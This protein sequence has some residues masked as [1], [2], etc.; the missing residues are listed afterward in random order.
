MPEEKPGRSLSAVGTPPEFLEA[1]ERRFGPIILDLAAHRGNKVAGSYFAPA[2]LTETWDPVKMGRGDLMP[3]LARLVAAGAEPN[4]ASAAIARASD[5]GEKTE[6][7]VPNHDTKHAGFDAL[8][9]N[10][11]GPGLAFL[12][13]PYD[14]IAPWAK[15]CA[16]SKR[17]IAFLVPLTC[18]NWAANY[19][20]G[21][22]LVL[23]LRP[24]LR[25]VGHEQGYPKDLML[26]IYGVTPADRRFECW[27]WDEENKQ[28]DI[29]N[30]LK[31]RRARTPAAAQV[32][33]AA[34]GTNE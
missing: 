10:W 29:T 27:R 6:I 9:Q 23:G 32:P 14:N 2:M 33:I 20:H 7:S 4:E 25:F 24:R 11:T 34:L 12:N 22:A 8:T 21:H 15:K 18:S 28:L 17:R 1:V 30:R 19:V 3:I 13:P 31:P 26:A 5:A 16:E